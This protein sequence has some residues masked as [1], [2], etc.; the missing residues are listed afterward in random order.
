MTD[1][2][3][4][5]QAQFRAALVAMVAE[6]TTG[7]SGN[8]T[9]LVHRALM[10]GFQLGLIAAV[11]ECEK[12]ALSIKE[13]SPPVQGHMTC[14]SCHGWTSDAMAF[15]VNHLAG[16]ELMNSIAMRAATAQHLAIRVARRAQAIEPP[17][18]SRMCIGCAAPA[19]HAHALPSGELLAWCDK[20]VPWVIHWEKCGEPCLTALKK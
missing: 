5:W 20:H 18:T 16:C 19:A 9:E 3:E 6:E 14:E 15:P 8:R 13:P 17:A 2:R 7:P 10:H 11:E 4:T 12:Y 1:K